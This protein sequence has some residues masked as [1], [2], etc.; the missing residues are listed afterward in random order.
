[1]ITMGSRTVTIVRATM[2]AVNETINRTTIATRTVPTTVTI[3]DPRVQEWKQIIQKK[4]ICH[5]SALRFRGTTTGRT[6]GSWVTLISS[7]GWD[8]QGMSS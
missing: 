2:E 4:E 1:M 7:L 8:Q 6:M 5:R 3:N